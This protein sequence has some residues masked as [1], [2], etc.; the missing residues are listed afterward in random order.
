MHA[1][2]TAALRTAPASPES[3]LPPP[4]RNLEKPTALVKAQSL[5]CTNGDVFAADQERHYAPCPACRPPGS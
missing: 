4:V 2:T 1:T 5:A 3:A